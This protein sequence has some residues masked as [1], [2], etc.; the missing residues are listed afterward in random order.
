MNDFDKDLIR[1]LINDIE[2]QVSNL[3]GDRGGWTY[4]GLSSRYY[5]EIKEL[6][7]AGKLTQ[8]HVDRVYYVDYLLSIP[9][10]KDLS[11]KYPW[12][13]K[14]LFPAKV[15]GAGDEQL[16]FVVQ[17]SLRKQSFTVSSDGILGPKTARA[18]LSLSKAQEQVLIDDIRSN[19][20]NLVLAR[21][22]SVG[23]HPDGIRN[24]L[25]KEHAHAFGTLTGTT[26][27]SI[28]PTADTVIASAKLSSVSPEVNRSGLQVVESH[29]WEQLPLGMD[30][31]I[32]IR[33]VDHAS[34]TFVPPARSVNS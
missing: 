27:M 29:G 19:F 18:I 24:R 8:A 3:A 21:Q 13:I 6:Y 16:M 30:I 4:Q 31:V 23:A 25:I 9:Y 15:H 20:D 14:L 12:F 26:P 22:R 5:P 7:E 1:W 34:N 10:Y 33:G 2:G 28:L 32:E 11:T 17:D